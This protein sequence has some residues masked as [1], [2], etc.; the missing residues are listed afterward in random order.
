MQLTSAEL[1][2]QRLGELLQEIN[3]NFMT[4]LAILWYIGVENVNGLWLLKIKFRIEKMI[5]GGKKYER[6]CTAIE[7]ITLINALTGRVGRKASKVR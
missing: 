4:F 6:I 5:K 7:A 3:G 1:R 2:L